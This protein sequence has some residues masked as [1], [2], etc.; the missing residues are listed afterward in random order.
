M[1]ASPFS[2]KTDSSHSLKLQAFEYDVSFG[3][4]ITHLF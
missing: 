2:V 1:H 3:Y 4:K